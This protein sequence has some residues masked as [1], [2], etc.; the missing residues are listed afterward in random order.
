MVF[1]LG[2]LLLVASVC[3]VADQL[4]LGLGSGIAYSGNER[5]DD[6]PVLLDYDL[7]FQLGILTFGY[8]F[9]NGLRLE[10]EG[11]KRSNDLEI[12]EFDDARGLINTGL[13]DAVDSTSLMANVI[14][15][16]DPGIVVRPYLG[17]G[18]GITKLD[19]KLSNKANNDLILSDSDT[20]FAYQAIVGVGVPIGR[21]LHLSLDYRYWRHLEVDLQT[22]AAEPVSTE[23]PI[24]QVSVTLSYAFRSFETRKETP[25][26]EPASAG[27]YSELRAGYIAAEDSDIEDGLVDT[28]FDA[29][30]IGSAL[31]FAVGY[32][33]QRDSGGGWRGE[34]ELSRWQNNADVI[35]FGK[36]RGE[37][38]LSGSVKIL[39]VAG[40]LIYDFA[41][42][43]ALQP[44]AGLGIGFAEV[45]YD[46]TLHEAGGVTTPYVDDSDSGFAAQ[47][48][49]GMSVRLTSRLQASL[50]YRYWWAPAIEI[51]D[52]HQVKLKTEHSAHVLM[53]GL[54][55]HFGD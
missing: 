37:F 44:Y 2:V 21:R 27:W 24:Q 43:A 19:Y 5:F 22:E 10:L 4:Y 9:D 23:H 16:F 42:R 39:G 32:E 25:G 55:Y 7:G 33:W 38:R 50:N 54:R 34:L 31:S 49:L 35:D 48:L 14:Y 13:Q 15:E 52:P 28:N 53:L 47:A 45:D 41:P 46:V 51:T 20:T 3:A 30:D 29:F 26:W 17:I 12:I 8:A 6:T 11:A 1:G 18:I 40:N 36:L